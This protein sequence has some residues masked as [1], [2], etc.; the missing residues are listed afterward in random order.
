MA[1]LSP[2]RRAE[3]GRAVSTHWLWVLTSPSE[4]CPAVDVVKGLHWPLCTSVEYPV[5]SAGSSANAPKRRLPSLRAGRRR[6]AS[7]QPRGAATPSGAGANARSSRT[8]ATRR[9]RRETRDQSLLSYWKA[10]HVLL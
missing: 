10:L 3:A 1:G 7:E 8:A 5:A 4:I 6:Q 9:D 2:E